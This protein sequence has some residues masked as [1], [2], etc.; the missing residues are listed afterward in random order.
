M[1]LPL[2]RLSFSLF[3]FTL[4]HFYFSPGPTVL[5]ESKKATLNAEDEK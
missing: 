3:L 4:I 1:V 5:L 2:P